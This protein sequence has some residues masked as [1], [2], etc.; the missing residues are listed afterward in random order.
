MLRLLTPMLLFLT[1][2]TRLD[3]Q[4]FDES[5]F[6]RYTRM[7]GLSSNFISGIVQDAT[8]YI[9][10]ATHTG[11]N[12]FD[13]RFFQS[14]FTGSADVPLPANSITRLRLQGR[15]LL[16]STVAGAFALDPVSLEYKQLIIPCDSAIF[17]WTNSIRE[18]RSDH[19]GNYI[20]SS[21]TGLFVLDSLGRII[22]RHDRYL[23]PDV[24]RTELLYGGR[25]F[26]LG[27]GRLLQ[28]AAPSFTEYDPEHNRIDTLY[29]RG[30]PAFARIV[31][32]SGGGHKLCLPGQTD[33][34]FTL[35]AARN[36]L[37]RFDWK[38]G[39]VSTLS[40]PFN[41]AS[42]LD[43]SSDLFYLSDSL[44]ALTSRSGGFYLLEWHAAAH[45]LSCAGKKY[46]DGKRCTAI[47]RDREGRLW[48]GTTDGLYKENLSSPFF[49]AYDLAD[50]QPELKHF[51]IRAVFGNRDKLIIGLRNKGGILLLDKATKKVE[52]RVYLDSP[53]AFCNNISLFFP[54]SPDTLWVGT[55][56]GLFWLDERH[57]HTGRVSVPPELAWIYHSNFLYFYRDSRGDIWMSLGQLNS[58]VRYDHVTRQF[59]QLRPENNPL[60]KIT[61]CFSM[62]EDKRGNI[63]LAGDG[64]CRWN[65]TRDLVD[66]LIPYPTVTRRL[67][68]FMLIMAHDDDDNL[69]LNSY[70]N[71]ILQFN[72]ASGQMI[73]RLEE[74]DLSDAD[75]ATNSPIIGGYLWLGSD[76]GVSAFDLRDYSSRLF[77][78]ADGLPSVAIT[79]IRQGSFYDTAENQCYFGSLHHLISFR[80]DLSHTRQ[81]APQ[82]FVDEIRTSDSILCGRIGHVEV[83]YADNSLRLTFNAINFRNPEDNRFAYRVTPSSDS[84][85]HDLGWEHS[86][87][88]NN[89]APGLY[90][91]EL[92]LF[93]A[94]NRWPEQVKILAL[95]VYPPFWQRTW[96]IVLAAL[97]L[98]ALVVLIYRNRVGGI[99][100][101]LSL[102]KKLAEYEM[103]ALHAQMNPHFIFNALNSIREMILRSDNRNASRYLSRFAQLIRLNLEHS[104]LTFITLRQNIEYLEGYLEMEQMRFADFNYSIETDPD[105][106]LDE[107]RVAPMLIQPLVENAIWH[108]LRPQESDKRVRIHFYMDGDKLVCEIDDNGIGIR[109]SLEN[110]DIYQPGHRSMGID[111]IRQ[112]IA[113]LNEKYG[114]DCS[115]SIEDKTDIPGRTDGGT[116]ITLVVNETTT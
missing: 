34:L 40:L 79:T 32:D 67:R 65:R 105:I 15:K 80:P 87:N 110:K 37:D 83:P 75:V 50:Q 92:K 53:G 47:C 72:C 4:S 76:D 54:Y 82:L 10:V 51:A 1:V 11:L 31:S 26:A 2:F 30:H 69:W 95:T 66:T 58:V 73:L 20:L 70:D 16:G 77:T 115:L 85:W 17:F 74:T 21:K 99:R 107:V 13:G 46:F 114:M 52:R 100:E 81:E 90:R 28:E 108:G 84:V 55:Q 116:L 62:A 25:L 39:Q 113:V 6:T 63:W 104:R 112:R 43:E 101:K 61:F 68:N 24:G 106:D 57:Y 56:Q 41:G 71:G 19:K 45:R 60:F 5:G 98:A 91:I 18:T 59:R 48:V 38:D 27:D 89:L 22:L 35:D 94:N 109:R 23:A 7:Q 42:E 44:L 93:S 8:G 36:T 9:W 86:V 64:L 88:F 49:T 96:F 111:N 33:E 12:R 3:A 97:L 14:Y 103:K 29:D 78:Y 102:D